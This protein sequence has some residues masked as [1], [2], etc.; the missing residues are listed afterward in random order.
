MA[1]LS[2]EQKEVVE[3]RNCNILVSAAAGSGKTTVL[4]ER[5]IQRLKD[6]SEP[7]NIDEILVLTFTKAAA[8]EMRDRI[9]AAIEVELEKNPKD[10]HMQKQAM[11][12][13]N[14]QITTIDSFCLN[15]IKNNFTEIGLEPGF[16][17]AKEAEMTF[18][19][20]DI[21]EET[22]EELMNSEDIENID[23]FL[24]RFESKDNVNKIKQAILTAYK[25]AEKSPFPEE[26]FAQHK[27]DYKVESV[28]ALY[29]KDWFKQLYDNIILDIK[30]AKKEAEKLL[31]F[32]TGVGLE[33][34]AENVENDILLIE[35]LEVCKD[36]SELQNCILG[37]IK[38]QRLN[39]S[40]ID[41]ELKK[42][43]QNKRKLYKDL[44][45]RIKKDYFGQ[46]IESIIS[47][48]Q[49]TS[50]AVW[51]LMEGAHLFYKKLEKRKR[52]LKLITFS[53]MEHM[54]LKILLYKDGEEYH[55]TRVA[56]EYRKIFKELM[57]DEYQD[58]NHIQ[59]YIIHSISGEENG[60]FDRFMVGDIKQSIYRFRNANPELF[61]DKYLSY[62]EDMVDKRKIDLSMNY[63]SSAEVIDMVN[64][65]FERIMD[66]DIGGVD[67]DAASRLYCGI[68]RSID[69]ERASD[70]KAEL[71]VAKESSDSTLG[72]EELE[73]LMIAKRIKALV[74]EYK[75]WDGKQKIFRD[76]TYRDIVILVRS[77][78]SFT[79]KLKQVMEEQG[80]PAYVTS[81]TGYFNALEI[82]TLLNFV[83]VLNNPYNDT[84]FYGAMLSIFGGFNEN[85]VALL[86]ILCK[87]YLY[88]ALQY[89]SDCETESIYEQKV[90]LKNIDL[91]NLKAKSFKFLKKIEGY[92]KLIPYTPIN[93]LLRTIIIDNSYVEHMSALPMGN[94]RKANILMLLKKA[95]SFEE[96]GF[97]GLFNFNR[98]IEKL[99]KYES[100]E[101]EFITLDENADVVRIMTMHKSK[102]L[103]FPICI[104]ANLNKKMNR[105]DERAEVI[106]HDKYGMGL[107]YV[108]YERRAKYPDIRK[109]FIASMIHK[110]SLSEELRVLYVAMTRAKEKLIMTAVSDDLDMYEDRLM[111]GELVSRVLRV[112][113]SS[114]LDAILLAKTGDN[115]KNFC[116]IRNY[117]YD[118]LSDMEV[119]EAINLADLYEEIKAYMYKAPIADKA[120]D[121]MEYK[122]GDDAEGKIEDEQ[123]DAYVS[124]KISDSL[125]MKLNFKYEHD[126]LKNL[127]TKTSVSELKMKAINDGLL[128]SEGNEAA[129]LFKA[130][131]KEE[132][133]PS[134]IKKEIKEATGAT[135]GSA[136][137][138]I[139]QL[140]PFEK[141]TDV[142][143]EE[144]LDIFVKNFIESG[145]LTKEEYELVD[146]GKIC[147]FFGSNLGKRMT[148]A[149][150]E[151]KLY[152]EQPFVLG[153]S[154]E[155]LNKEFPK[156]ESILIQGIIDAY[157]L[158]GNKIVLMDYKTDKVMNG[159]E[160]IKKYKTQ[161][162]YY[163]EALKRITGFEVVEKLLYSFALDEVL[164]VNTEV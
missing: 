93:D 18:L 105:M 106:Y 78:G 89:V 149:A 110:D 142:I 144:D 46:N 38:W 16:R 147:K 70:R 27:N 48:M 56:L 9:A 88:E 34:Y 63:R 53:D 135:R 5:I 49:E 10:E 40:S 151:G 43:A 12:I 113:I 72:G 107:N 136:Y 102:G 114:Y 14:A 155:R 158:E 7:V 124:S 33:D 130:L 59:E 76:C 139:M 42:Q 119:V 157:F 36:Y 97:K 75:V 133:I 95:E 99:H 39:R 1:E 86:K 160:L 101:G 41:E 103:E 123:S 58:S 24:E 44:I 115:W 131:D 125:T 146:K 51:A 118:D 80:L 109:K 62:K 6:A 148:V 156:D 37:G 134:F 126:N 25:E 8:G 79:D 112:K 92:R 141:I 61:A 55:P 71:L 164:N 74:S 47:N 132:Y 153:I 77:G 96:D 13:Y 65:V 84:P 137:H 22:I 116:D 69:K 104:L 87:G 15:L 35:A 163:E 138:H 81:K 2:K 85:E 45:D 108:D 60:R 129:E 150:R 152:L 11:L 117:T 128:N 143:K 52:E 32:I 64:T 121:K 68:E 94:Q 154:A 159:N 83:S 19:T 120:L 17:L 91:I 28:E 26:Y 162:D 57:V 23:S 73:S 145:Q 111:E 82:V 21:L 4:V 3:L 29:G 54:A 122:I 30:G 90:E 161:L 31:D 66:K 100:D 98:Y 127:Y 140:M 67:Y 20:E 50:K